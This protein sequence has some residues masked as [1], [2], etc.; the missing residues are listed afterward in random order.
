MAASSACPPISHMENVNY[1]MKAYFETFNKFKYLL[2]NLISRDFKVKY[3]RSVL[4]IAWSLLNP[5]LMMLILSAVFSTLMGNRV[6]INFPFALFVISGQT[7]FNFFN[8]ATSNANYAII[9]AAPLIQKVYVPKYIFPL[10][11]MLF[12]FINMLIALIAIVVMLLI[13]QIPFRWTMLLFPIP[14]FALL[15]FSV[16][17]GL[18]LS[19]L[20][21]FFRDL[22]HLYSVLTMAWMYLTPIIYPVEIVEGS[23]IRNVVWINPLTW[24]VEYFRTLVLYGPVNGTVPTLE[25]NLVCFGWGVGLFLAGILV[26]RK[27]QDKFILH[28]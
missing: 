17:L 9:D 28:I 25:M 21:V 14:L 15:L 8:E 4:G 24:Y 3:R 5:I 2:K 11:K 10:E 13:Y 27:L 26:F 16:G 22:K 19:A 6:D 12:A 20:C 23:W 1:K 18:I 7:L